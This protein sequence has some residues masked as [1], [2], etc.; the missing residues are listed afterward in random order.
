MKKKE[1]I[2]INLL[3]AVTLF[4]LLMLI[5]VMYYIYATNKSE[6]SKNSNQ[7]SS[8][9][10]KENTTSEQTSSKGFQMSKEDYPKIDGATAMWPMSVQIAKEVLN[11]SDDEAENFVVHNTTSKF[12]FL[13]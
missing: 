1:S 3:T 11:M 6:I 8:T 13:A 12:P 9:N 10:I 5:G 7:I 4:I 2:K